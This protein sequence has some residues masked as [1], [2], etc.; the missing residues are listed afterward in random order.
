MDVN[1]IRN[2]IAWLFWQANKDGVTPLVTRHDV[3]DAM[4]LEYW[5]ETPSVDSVFDGQEKN[6][7]VVETVYAYGNDGKRVETYYRFLC[8]NTD[9]V[10]FLNENK[11]V[12]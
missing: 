2:I 11:V 10:K 4:G 7:R 6:V 1:L 8:T 3:Y 5:K 12:R 9:A